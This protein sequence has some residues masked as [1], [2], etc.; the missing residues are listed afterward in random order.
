MEHYEIAAYGTAREYARQL[1]RQPDVEV[2]STTI[3]EEGNAEQVLTQL[4]KEKLNFEA[5]VV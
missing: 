1:G 4:A 5:K 3:E 2:L